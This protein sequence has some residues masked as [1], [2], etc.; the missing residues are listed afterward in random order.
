GWEVRFESARGVEVEG[1][2]DSVGS[3]WDGV[4]V[5]EVFEESVSDVLRRGGEDEVVEGEGEG[6]VVCGR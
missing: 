6:M 4:M 1:V 5:V 3:Q 2:I